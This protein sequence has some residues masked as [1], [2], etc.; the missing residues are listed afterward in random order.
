MRP[1]G[2]AGLLLVTLK[3]RLAVASPSLTVTVMV[4]EPVGLATGVTVKLR[5]APLPPKTMFATGTMD[6]LDDAADTVKLATAVSLSPTVKA[7]ASVLVAASTDWSAIALI[8]GAV[9]G[10]V[11]VTTNESD[12][13]APWPSISVTVTVEE[14]VWPTTGVIV[15]VRVPP[16][17][18]KTTLAT[19]MSIRFDEDAASVRLL[20]ADCA[21]LTEKLTGPTGTPAVVERSAML[22]MLGGVLG[23]T[24][25]TKDCDE[26]SPPASVTV[27]VIVPD[28]VWP[29]A[30]VT[31]AVRL[32][33]LPPR[34]T[35]A[36]GITAGLEEATLKLRLP[37]AVSASPTVNGIAAV[38]LPA[39]MD[40]K[41][42]EVMVGA[43]FT[44]GAGLSAL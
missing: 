37:A 24:V 21:S 8:V 7:M 10:A 2:G 25:T 34:M 11:T 22:A 29:L 3:V 39:V 5:L 19:G 27:M 35:F 20:A 30:G 17:P 4:A 38:L 43:V 32:A 44:P 16:L 41:A 13:V 15:M 23:L 14:P 28:P 31:V 6:G 12:A 42:M 33:P 36:T 40:W 18:P 26:L 1:L 9:F